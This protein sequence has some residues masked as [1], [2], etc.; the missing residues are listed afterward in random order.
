M[1]WNGGRGL[2]EP[3]TLHFPI[4][5]HDALYH[6][7]LRSRPLVQADIE[8]TGGDQLPSTDGEKLCQALRSFSRLV[9]AIQSSC[10]LI[11]SCQRHDLK[12]Y[13]GKGPSFEIDSDTHREGLNCLRNFGSSWM[14]VHCPE[15]GEV[16]IDARPSLAQPRCDFVMMQTKS[17]TRLTVQKTLCLQ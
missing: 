17:R 8:R 3:G 4:L 14:K 12:P 2:W 1:I 6:A 15:V 13:L 5:D 10:K 16:G 11:S 9:P 7:M